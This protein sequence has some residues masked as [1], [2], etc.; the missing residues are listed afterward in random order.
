MQPLGE[1]HALFC[2]RFEAVGVPKDGL[3]EQVDFDH[4]AEIVRAPP[5]GGERARAGR[6]VELRSRSA[7]PRSV[8][9]RACAARTVTV[10]SSKD[11][12]TAGR[13]DEQRGT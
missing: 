7:I 2:A 11:P 4:V 10:R 12:R 5:T 8:E 13:T 3:R 1:G 6:R 9:A